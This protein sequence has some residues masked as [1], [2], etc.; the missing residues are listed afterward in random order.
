MSTLQLVGW[1]SGARN[2]ENLDVRLLPVL[3]L[4]LS[5]LGELG[6]AEVLLLS[7]R[8]F[9]LLAKLTL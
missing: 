6:L 3:Q 8:A 7:I 1:D 4:K 2:A 5:G 9:E